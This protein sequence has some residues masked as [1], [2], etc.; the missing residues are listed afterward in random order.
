LIALAASC[1]SQSPPDSR[2]AAA[3][4]IAA[5]RAFAERHQSVSIKQSFGEFSAPDGVAV[6]PDGV[7]NVKTFIAGWPDRADAGFILWWPAFAGIARSGDLGFTTGPASFGGGRRYTDY[8]TIWRR[9]PDG[10]WKWM[11]DLGTDKGVKPAGGPDD[12]VATVPLPAVRPLAPARA[13]AELLALDTA[14][15][16]ASGRDAAALAP[17]FAPEARAIGW[18]EAPV[19]GAAAIAAA[20]ARRPAMAMKPAGGGVSAAGDFG[21]TY[22]YA[23]WTEAGQAKRGPSLR[24]WQRRSRGWVILVDNVHPF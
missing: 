15:G 1:T 22:G 12:P 2:A 11:I 8:F 20:L 3:P 18:D 23:D 17:R 14:L 6:T 5:E 19:T 4:V 16:A 24:A 21:W 7:V 10:G 9:Q 13:W